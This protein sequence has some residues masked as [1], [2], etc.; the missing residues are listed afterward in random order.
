MVVYMTSSLSQ[1]SYLQDTIFYNKLFNFTKI[2]I[3]VLPQNKISF[4]K[5]SSD[6]LVAWIKFDH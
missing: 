3:S 1:H 2:P 6:L 4:V 5:E